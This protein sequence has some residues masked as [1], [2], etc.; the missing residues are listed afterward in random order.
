MNVSIADACQVPAFIDSGSELNALSLSFCREHNI[1]FQKNNRKF[2]L[3]NNSVFNS[4]GHVRLRVKYEE[5]CQLL[6]FDIFSSCISN[7][8]LGRPGLRQFGV[9]L[10]FAAMSSEDVTVSERL[11]LFQ[12]DQLLKLIR[13]YDDVFGLNGTVVKG[14]E[15]SVSLKSGTK[16]FISKAYKVPHKLENE[17]NE[18]IE[19]MLSEGIIRK[20]TSPWRSPSFFVKKKEWKVEICDR[21]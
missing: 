7:V 16:P 10:S 2:C 21:F 15:H 19:Q 13:D 8:I 12:K 18:Q 6:D 11:S 9:V 20:S 3:A 1:S 5:E 17:M 4:I 14:F